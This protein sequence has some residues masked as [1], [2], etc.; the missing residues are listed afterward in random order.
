MKWY[1]KVVRDNYTNFNG[2]AR[3]EEYWMFVLFNF[4]FA[5]G[6][7]IISGALAN[8]TDV[9]AFIGLY[10]IYILAIIIPSL[11]VA[12]RRLHDINKSGWFYLV[13][14]IPLIGGIWLLV[15]FVTEGDV[16]PNNYG[17]DPKRPNEAEI[18]KI[19]TVS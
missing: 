9:P 8:L 16:G 3:R 6:I 15:L 17:P 12:V 7:V 11:A 14:L 1:L 10:F 5:I 13:G 19:G 2:R 4:L 18:N